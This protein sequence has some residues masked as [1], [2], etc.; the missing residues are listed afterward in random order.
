MAA[1]S[2]PLMA[3]WTML[4]CLAGAV[5]N[6]VCGVREADAALMAGKPLPG[7]FKL[8]LPCAL[9]RD[10]SA[11]FH[12]APYQGKYPAPHRA[13]DPLGMQKLLAGM[14]DRGADVAVVECEADGLADGRCRPPSCLNTPAASSQRLPCCSLRVVSRS[15]NREGVSPQKVGSTAAGVPAETNAGIMQRSVHHHWGISR[16]SGKLWE[17]C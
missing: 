16:G 8:R 11:A 6:G 14:A 10:C 9:R 3:C 1:C 12:L 5:S 4:L 15:M 7:M 13:P 2:V 17:G